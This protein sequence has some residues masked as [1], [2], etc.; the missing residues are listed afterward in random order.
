MHSGM[1]SLTIII[2]NFMSPNSISR[3]FISIILCLIIIG[4]ARNILFK[5]TLSKTDMLEPSSSASRVI[6]VG[7]PFP[8]RVN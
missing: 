8:Q 4:M 7:S 6:F 3:L 2:L 1:M 5:E